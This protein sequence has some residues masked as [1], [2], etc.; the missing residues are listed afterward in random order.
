MRKNWSKEEVKLLT[1]NYTIYGTKYCVKLLNRTE[2][3]I[4]SKAA[5]LKLTSA[6][7]GN[8]KK[9]HK[10]HEND[11]FELEADAYPQELYKG[12]LIPIVYT[13]SKEHTWK[14]TPNSI[15]QGSSCPYCSGKR[16]YTP[17]E[18]ADKIKPIIPLE[19]YSDGRLLILHQ[20]PE[21]H[22][23]KA[24][25]SHILTGKGCP[26]CAKYGFKMDKPAI[27]YYLK[28]FNENIIYYKIGVTGDSIKNRFSKDNDKT[29]VPIKIINFATGKEAKEYEQ[30]LLLK[31]NHHRSKNLNWLK[32]KGN[33]EL[34]TF[35]VLELDK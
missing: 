1:E 34:F 35:D 6:Y 32:S 25:P 16:T 2:G 20:C 4:R 7:E 18:Y 19:D 14:T 10:D 17:K 26:H 30:T 11:L 12:S 5:T 31:H 8:K 9:T 13:C 23:W 22:E 21:G 15:L 29:F 27:F 24:R 28:I 3:S 33:T